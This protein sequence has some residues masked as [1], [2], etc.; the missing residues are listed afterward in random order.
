MQNITTAMRSYLLISLKTIVRNIFYEI[1]M[2]YER[3]LKNKVPVCDLQT[4]TI[5]RRLPPDAVCVDIGVNEGQLFNAMSKHCSKGKLYGFEPITHLYK[6]LSKRYRGDHIQFF[7][8]A[9]SDKE[10]EASFYYFPGRTGVSGF[11]RRW[12]LFSD[13]KA[14]EMTIRTRCFDAILDLPRI[15][16]I[17]IDVEGLELKVLKGT[18]EH[19]IRCRP[20]IIF[21]CGYGAI[22]YYKGTPEEVFAFF[23][24]IGYSISLLKPYL[25]GQLPFDRH[26]FIYFFKHGYEIQY[27]AYPFS[28]NS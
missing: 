22:D 9:L 19:L 3:F 8:I 25:A 14:E 7:P 26:T 16:L 20:V 27:I 4:I 15:D 28:N 10:E 12:A 17:K 23:D 2:N 6:Y 18:R 1:F 24:E 21:E 13:L 5:I 11:S